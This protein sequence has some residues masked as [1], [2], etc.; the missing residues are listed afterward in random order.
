MNSTNRTRVPPIALAFLLCILLPLP[1]AQDTPIAQPPAPLIVRA[2]AWLS[3]A[4]A[5]WVWPRSALSNGWKKT[6]FPWT[7]SR[8]PAW[9]ALLAPCMPP[10]CRH[11]R[12]R[13][14]PKRST[15]TQ[16]C[17]R[18]LSLLSSPIAGQDRQDFLIDAPF[19]LKHG[20]SG[21][22]GFNPGR[23]V[24]LLLDRI[25]LRE[26][27]VA[28]FDDLPIPFRCVATDMLS[29]EGVVLR[30]GAWLRRCGPPWRSPVYLRRS[31]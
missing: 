8:E 10:G 29:G 15:G 4:A 6:I 25:A 30:D 3:A 14:L 19:G 27:G 7:A 16:R 9:E 1:R 12:L 21:P 22:N 5:R 31:R 13:S 20:L 26:S 18:N 28:S 17:C 23:G 24:G 2:S 11:P